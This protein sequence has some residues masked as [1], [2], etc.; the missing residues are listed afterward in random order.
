MPFDVLPEHYL[1]ERNKQRER[2]KKRASLRLVFVSA[3]IGSRVL[4]T[5]MGIFTA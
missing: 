3:I 5:H 4:Q 1:G 2:E